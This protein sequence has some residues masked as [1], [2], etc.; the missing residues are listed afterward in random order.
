MCLQRS[1]I[2]SIFRSLFY[3]LDSVKVP[4]MVNYPKSYVLPILVSLGM[5]GKYIIDPNQIK[6]LSEIKLVAN[7]CLQNVRK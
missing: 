7:I 6:D 4:H 3:I 2:V 1:C 5:T